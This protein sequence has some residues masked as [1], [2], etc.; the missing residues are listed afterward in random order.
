MRAV[1]FTSF[2]GP[3]L[4]KVTDAPIP[5]PGEGQIRIAVR[6]CGVNPFDWKQRRGMFGGTLPIRVGVEVAGIVDAIG[7]S[8]GGKVV[9]GDRVY[10]FSVGGGAAEFALCDHYAPIPAALDFVT[11][12]AMPVAVETAYRVLDL[13]NVPKGSAV[14]V[15]GGSGAVGQAIVQIA[16]ARGAEVIATASQANHPLLMG[17]GAR[18]VTYGPGLAERSAHSV[19]QG[20]TPR[21]MRAAAAS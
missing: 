17:L 1:S 20:S 18:P 2:G 4:L 21:S 8:E 12:A 7:S 3:E 6:A 14:L 15:N 19:S 5:A 10:G 13:L 16:I 11:A 9:V